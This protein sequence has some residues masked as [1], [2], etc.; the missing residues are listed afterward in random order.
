MKKTLFLFSILLPFLFGGAVLSADLEQSALIS[1]EGASEV[2]H[3]DPKAYQQMQRD[4]ES[5]VAQQS[6]DLPN[7]LGTVATWVGVLLLVVT[8][9]ETRKTAKAAR[10][11]VD[12]ARESAEKQLRAYVT[13]N[14]VEIIQFE[15]GKPLLVRIPMTNTGQTPAHEY[16]GWFYVAMVPNSAKDRFRFGKADT[17]SRYTLGPGVEATAYEASMDN[18]SDHLVSELEYETV[19][20]GDRTLYVWGRDYYV[21][22]FGNPHVTSYR[23]ERSG[24][25]DCPQ[26][27]KVCA[28]GNKST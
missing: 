21:D 12:D 3:T 16:R 14:K 8:L 4:R 7:I 2:A 23:Y 13:L 15:V 1:D 19:T 10:A 27:M 20:S 22:V 11:A 24:P 26:R 17:I 18:S 9:W 6:M 28:V 25:V 5:F